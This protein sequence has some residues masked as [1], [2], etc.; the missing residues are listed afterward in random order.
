MY[1]ASQD[2]NIRKKLLDFSTFIALLGEKSSLSSCHA[3]GTKS[4][5]IFSEPL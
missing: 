4:L 2:A 1:T 3:R 5:D